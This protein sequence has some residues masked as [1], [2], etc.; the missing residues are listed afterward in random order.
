MKK[1]DEAH[2]ILPRAVLS[3]MDK[4]DGSGFTDD[5]ALLLQMYSYLLIRILEGVRI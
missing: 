4:L 1:R 5:D 2:E 3:V